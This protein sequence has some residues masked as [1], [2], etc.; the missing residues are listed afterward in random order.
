MHV[1]F[2]LILWLHLKVN[3]F[4]IKLTQKMTFLKIS[5]PGGTN[6]GLQ[7]RVYGPFKTRKKE[8][9]NTTSLLNYV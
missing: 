3:R 1:N 4:Q 7:T 6:T 2:P 9:P 8:P 5:S